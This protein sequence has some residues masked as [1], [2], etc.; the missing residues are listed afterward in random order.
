[1]V[2]SIVRA[3][4]KSQTRY[5]RIRLFEIQRCEQSVYYP[6]EGTVVYAPFRP[7]KSQSIDAPRNLMSV[8]NS[9]T[10]RR[11]LHCLAQS[12]VL[13]WELIAGLSSP[14]GTSACDDDVN[15]CNVFDRATLRI[16]QSYDGRGGRDM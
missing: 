14:S 10:C 8:G 15:Q 2:G 4:W 3:R 5:R 16:L 9:V 12:S 6:R 13:L 11:L 1:M 7:L